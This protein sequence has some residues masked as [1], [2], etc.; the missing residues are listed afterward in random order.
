V[1]TGNKGP[2]IL[3]YKELK[4]LAIKNNLHLGIGCTTGGAL[5]S[6]NCGFYDLAG[7]NIELIQGVLNGTSNYILSEMQEKNISYEDA[8]SEAKR[9]NIAEANP[10]LDV[11]GFDTACKII[12]LGNALLGSDITLENIKIEG[13]TNITLRDIQKAKKENKK[14]KLIGTVE[15]NN[16]NIN[17]YVNIEYIDNKHPLYFVDYKNKGVYY[18]TDILGD[19]SII[20]GASSTLNAAAAILRDL[21]NIK[22]EVSYTRSM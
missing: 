9:L 2:I 1:I 4:E 3:K 7:A 15:N 16:G 21:I 13:I 14:I 8:L 17:T 6:I 19:I 11:E 10:S 5:P 12:I 18:K 20:G 22:N